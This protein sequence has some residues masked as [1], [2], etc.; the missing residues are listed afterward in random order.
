MTFGEKLQALRKARRWSQEELAGQINVSRQALGKWESGAS[1]PDT[2][3]V[4][5]LSRLFGV[6]TDYL[7]LEGGSAAGGV[8]AAAAEET[9]WPKG[10]V[11]FLVTALVG[12]VLY[13]GLSIWGDVVSANTVYIG[14]EPLRG[15]R[16]LL[17]AYHLQWVAV[18]LWLMMLGGFIGTLIYTADAK[19]RFHAWWKKNVAE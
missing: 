11:A 8:Q 18:L 9:K 16:A 14:M 5:A 2:E 4:I 1:V 6:T 17:R 13:L 12:L 10:R 3:N 7:L 19:E 15:V